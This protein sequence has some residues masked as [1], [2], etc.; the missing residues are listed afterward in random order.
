MAIMVLAAKHP[1]GI[2]TLARDVSNGA[3]VP[4][5]SVI[6]QMDVKLTQV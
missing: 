2:R 6:L 1:A 3:T 5:I 4:K